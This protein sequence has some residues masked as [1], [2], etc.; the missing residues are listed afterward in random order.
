MK[1]LALFFGCTLVLLSAD[2]FGP[3]WTIAPAPDSIFHDKT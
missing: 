3:K 1:K 2:T